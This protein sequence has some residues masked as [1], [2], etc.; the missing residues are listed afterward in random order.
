MVFWVSSGDFQMPRKTDHLRWHHGQW[1]VRIAIP[2][3][4]RAAFGGKSSLTQNLGAELNTANRLK[5]EVLTRFRS[6]IAQA[7]NPSA[8]LTDQAGPLR[9]DWETATEEM[10]PDAFMKVMR[11]TDAVEQERGREASDA[12]FKL[13]TGQ[14]TPID[15]YVGR[16]LADKGFVGKTA[17][18]HRMAIR[19]LI[20]WC[21]N[22]GKEATIDAIT[23]RVARDFIA[24]DLRV[25]LATISTANRYLSTYRTYWTWLMRDDRVETNP[26]DHTHINE[27]N[28]PH[29]D[30]NGDDEDTR[31]FE[32]DEIRKLLK[33]TPSASYLPDLMLLG[34]LTGARIDAI[35]NLRVRDCAGGNFHI[36]KA[37]KEKR[38]RTVPIHPDLTAIVAKR[39]SGKEPDDFLI[40]ELPPATDV[41]PR[42]GI[43]SKAFRRY[44]LKLGIDERPNGQRQSNV[45]FHSWRR[46]FITMAEQAGQEPNI[47]SFYVGHKRPGMSLG[48]YSEGP[49]ME[50]LRACVEAVQLPA[51]LRE[52]AQR[53]A[54]APLRPTL[55]RK[56]LIPKRTSKGLSND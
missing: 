36:R 1:Q 46:W 5:G 12:F 14:T 49:S 54:T 11:A 8:S 25:S 24:Q 38:A 3:D 21:I 4:L 31:W 23:R 52:T 51:D 48:L 18:Q 2:A 34:A 41:K 40:H 26:W 53:I 43:A 47:F 19:R 32:D 17:M 45:N 29:D 42:S 30:D 56:K 9:Q 35:C 55:H 39:T 10:A 50:Q 15:H 27:P 22:K 28:R 16:W 37:K 20:G 44:R 6:A 33:G 7:R 13:T